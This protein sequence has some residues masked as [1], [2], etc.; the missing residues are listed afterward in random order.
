M[1]DRQ[2][3]LIKAVA[4]VFPN[5]P[6]RFCLRHIYSNFQTAGFRGE[7]LK[8]CMDKA[9]YAY[10]KDVFDQGME[11]MKA[12]CLQA[13]EWLSKIPVHTWARWAFDTNCKT[14]L[15]NNNLSE[16]FNKYILDVR[17]K[18]IV[19]M[20]V[21]I[22]D[23]QMVRHDGKRAGGRKA[24]WDITPHYA[25]RL[26]INKKYSRDC[27]PKKADV[28]LWQVN[29]GP[30]THAVNMNDKTCSC[31]KWQ[32]TGLPCN[33]AVSAIY[34]ASQHPEDFVS[35]FFKKTFYLKSYNPVFQPTPGQHAWTKTNTVDIMPPAFKD[36]LKG[37]RAEKRRKGK[38]EV[39][40]PKETSRMATITCSNCKLQGHKYTSCSV[41]LRPD[42]LLR[43]NNHKV[44]LQQVKVTLL[45]FLYFLN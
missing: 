25:E 17:N 16:C 29:S 45:Q 4:T 21:G 35:D 40:A 33:H 10:T 9:A 44:E 22:Y 13:W 5:C 20:L 39:P 23:K 12:Q 24:G 30:A 8:K 19:T 26:E 7:D 28:G 43:K 36:H 41:P 2:K 18:P 14:D 3:G 34:K 15:V 38:F 1:S 32:L 6:V 27:I 31:R 11:E 37:R 42:L